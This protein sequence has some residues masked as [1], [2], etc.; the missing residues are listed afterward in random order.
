MI[1]VTPPPPQIAY[2]PTTLSELLAD[3]SDSEHRCSFYHSAVL[4]P[5]S[6]SGPDSYSA[7]GAVGSGRISP[8]NLSEYFT[9]VV[10]Q[11]VMV[12]L[13]CRKIAVLCLLRSGRE[14]LM[15]SGSNP[16]ELFEHG[17]RETTRN[18]WPFS[19]IKTFFHR[20]SQRRKFLNQYPSDN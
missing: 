9:S 20:S 8:R 6:H 1:A 19:R 7:K 5:A 17:C 16:R 10:E 2:N 12:L 18:N 3:D 4:K 15:T 13:G 11:T 14:P